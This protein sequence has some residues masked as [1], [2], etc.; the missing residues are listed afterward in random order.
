MKTICTSIAIA[1]AAVLQAAVVPTEWQV[2]ID[3][4][5]TD[6]GSTSHYTTNASQFVVNKNQWPLG[7]TVTI[8]VSV[9]FAYN[10][11]GLIMRSSA[12]A[13]TLIRHGD[14]LVRD[15]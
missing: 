3:F 13:N 8:T 5:A 15:D 14:K 2:R 9:L 12:A 10:G 7:E 1:L 6:T 11:T 4:V